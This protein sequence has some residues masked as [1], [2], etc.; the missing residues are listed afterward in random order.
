MKQHPEIFWG[1]VISMYIGNVLLIILNLPLIGLWLQVLKIPYQILFPLILSFCLIGAYSLNG[2]VI[3]VIIMLIF[4]IVGY[5]MRKFKYEGAPLVLA[6]V[7]GPMLERSFIQSLHMSGGSYGIF[8]NRPVSA[9]SM[10]VAFLIVIS[11]VLPFSSMLR[12]LRRNQG[13]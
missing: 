10:I 13:G 9:V 4:G 7:L 6:L 1:T 11:S 8:F 3:D 2:N 5:L 12:S